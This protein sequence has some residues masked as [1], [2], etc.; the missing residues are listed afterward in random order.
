MISQRS[1]V[2]LRVSLVCAGCGTDGLGAMASEAISRR[3]LPPRRGGPMNVRL[4]ALIHMGHSTAQVTGPDKPGRRVM[5][6]SDPSPVLPPPAAQ[7]AT[8]VIGPAAQVF[9]GS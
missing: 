6:I 9:P 4:H 5:L 3:S 7:H 8:V 2:A 1:R